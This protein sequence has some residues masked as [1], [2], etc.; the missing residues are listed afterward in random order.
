MFVRNW[1]RRVVLA[2]GLLYGLL[3]IISFIVRDRHRS[4]VRIDPTEHT[5]DV[6]AVDRGSVT[7]ARIRIAYREFAPGSRR[8]LETIVLPHENSGVKEDFG[9]LAAIQT[10]NAHVL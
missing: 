3:L 10:R 5:A 1:S 9:G 2:V 8:A 4:T 6:W 7:S